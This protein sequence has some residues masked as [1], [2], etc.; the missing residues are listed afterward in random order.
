MF[1]CSAGTIARGP[2]LAFRAWWSLFRSSGS[3]RRHNVPV[4]AGIV[5]RSDDLAWLSRQ[6]LYAAVADIDLLRGERLGASKDRP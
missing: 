5:Q 2:R 4:V 6:H 3:A 1:S